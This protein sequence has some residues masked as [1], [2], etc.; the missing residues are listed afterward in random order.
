MKATRLYTGPDGQ[1]RFENIE[2]EL[3]DCGDIGCLS[4]TFAVSG[5]IF[6]ETHGDYHYEWHNAPRRQ[7]IVMLKGAVEIE[8]GSGERRVF[9]A[10]DILL[11]EDT[12][13]QGHFSRAVK[14]EP[15]KSLFIPLE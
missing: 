13:G 15:R 4:E 9:H 12:S 1:S 6:R 8:V 5:L 10:G 11:A 14:G 7:Y 3:K 2:I